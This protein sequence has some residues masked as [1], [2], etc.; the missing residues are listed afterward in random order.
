MFSMCFHLMD[1]FLSSLTLIIPWHVL[2]VPKAVRINLTQFLSTC[3]EFNVSSVLSKLIKKFIH[4]FRDFFLLFPVLFGVCLIKFIS[5]FFLYLITYI[6]N[7]EYSILFKP[8]LFGCFLAFSA[9]VFTFFKQ[10]K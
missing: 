5:L 7:F 4:Y 6:T 9:M 1:V 10:L 8:I 2:Q 3:Y